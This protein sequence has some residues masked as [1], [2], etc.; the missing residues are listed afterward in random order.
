MKPSSK[1]LLDY[2]NEFGLIGCNKD[3]YIKS[4]EDIGCTWQDAI[5]LIDIHEIFYCKIYRH[6]TVYLSKELYFLLK[7]IQENTSLSTNAERIYRIL[8]NNPPQSTEML[9]VVSGLGKKEMNAAQSELL[10][11]LLITAISSYKSINVNWSSFLYGTSFQW[12]ESGDFFQVEDSKD[13]A[14]NKAIHILEK[15]LR[16]SD[17]TKILKIIS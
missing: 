14:K 8:E 4:L 11:K 5:H 9:K 12:E 17:V 2:I 13:D 15:T 6:K 3:P 1:I 16:K 7:T 10:E